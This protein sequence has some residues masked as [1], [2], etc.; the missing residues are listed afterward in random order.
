MQK[1]GFAFDLKFK[2]KNNNRNVFMVQTVQFIRAQSVKLKKFNN[3]DVFDSIYLICHAFVAGL[4][5]I[6]YVN[7]VLTLRII[8]FAFEPI[9]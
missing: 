7:F 4:S 5:L 3:I 6:N 8:R 1:L 2:L 9:D